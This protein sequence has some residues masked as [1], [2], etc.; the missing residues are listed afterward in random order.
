[1]PY[2][3]VKIERSGL[4]I[5]G[6][7]ASFKFKLPYEL[8]YVSWVNVVFWQ[9][10]YEGTLG[11]SLRINKEF[12]NEQHF[13]N[14]TSKELVVTLSGADTK[15][16]TDKLK[17]R[18]QMK[19]LS[20]EHEENGQIIPSTSFGSRTELFTVYP[21]D[22]SIMDGSMPEDATVEN[23]YIIL[24]GDVIPVVTE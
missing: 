16:F 8:Q 2:L 15:A 23:G 6:T 24:D 3:I 1:M 13:K 7:T 12:T 17:A 21:M 4:M 14:M 5:R 9:D 18:V 22:D 10:G 19:G 20:L 11:N